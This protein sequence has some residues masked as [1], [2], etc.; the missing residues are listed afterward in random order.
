MPAKTKPEIRPEIAPVAKSS[1][2][3]AEKTSAKMTKK[4]ARSFTA[5][6]RPKRQLTIPGEICERLG[7]EPGD[8]LELSLEDTTLVAKPRKSIALDTLREIQEAFKRSGITEEELLE[9]TYKI[10]HGET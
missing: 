1:S 4:P 8:A 5:V 7:I 10:R 2:P 9:E 3:K 6:L